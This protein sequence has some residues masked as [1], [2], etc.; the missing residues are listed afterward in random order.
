MR[1]IA[2]IAALVAFPALADVYNVTITMP[3]VSGAAQ[4]KPYVGSTALAVRPCGSAQSYP[5]AIP[6]EGTYSF[7]YSGVSSTG[8]EGDRGPVAVFV[9]DKKPGTPTT[10][11]TVVIRCRDAAGAD[12]VCPTN[13]TITALP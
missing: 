11:P 10:P 4:C 1:V 3:P 2:A 9:I 6:S 12:V 13:I 8:L 7:S 5:A